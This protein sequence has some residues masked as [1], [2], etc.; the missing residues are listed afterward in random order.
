MIGR[1]EYQALA[2]AVAAGT[3][4][5]P[6]LRMIRVVEPGPLTT[7]QDLGRRGYLAYGIPESGPIDRAAF[8]LAN[9]LVGN[10][11]AAAG[12]ECTLAGPRL[13]ILAPARS[14]RRGPRC[15]SA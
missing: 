1:A 8:V 4:T 11:D 14:R 5:P 13:E 10:P 3:F 15:R 2:A 12:L 9:R 6:S 7:V